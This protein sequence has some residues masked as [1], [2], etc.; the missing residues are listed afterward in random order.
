L[1]KKLSKFFSESSGEK[2]LEK[3][4]NKKISEIFFGMLFR[5]KD[6]EVFLAKF[7]K[8]NSQTFFRQ[9]ILKFF[10]G[11]STDISRKNNIIGALSASPNFTKS[12][13]TFW[14]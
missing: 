13:T 5:K 11:K 2:I 8:K 3:F 6:I 10:I 9:K 14:A 4:P 1:R 7:L 12:G